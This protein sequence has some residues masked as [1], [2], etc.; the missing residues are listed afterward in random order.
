VL[1]NV[2]TGPLF[3]GQP[4][5]EA[6]ALAHEWIGR[7][8]LSGFERHSRTNSPVACAN[9]WPW[10]RPLF[11]QP[12]ILLMDEPSAPSTCRRAP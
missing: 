7:V 11:N 3:R 8:G 6:L 1:S 5:A 4:K 9:A 2:A 12:Q 10:P